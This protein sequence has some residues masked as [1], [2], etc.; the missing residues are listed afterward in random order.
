MSVQKVNVLV[1]S[2]R[3]VPPG[4]AWL[5]RAAEWLFGGRDSAAPTLA[6]WLGEV[7]HRMAVNR[8]AYQVARDRDELLALASRY[9][10]TQPEFA[11][12]LIAAAR[13]ER[14]A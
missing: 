14:S 5:A 9:A 10:S 12:D 2:L 3:L 13:N 6:G 4:A 7:G 1:P 8:A 11:K